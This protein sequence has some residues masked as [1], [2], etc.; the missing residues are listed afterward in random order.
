MMRTDY[1]PETIRNNRK[2]NRPGLAG[3]KAS[4]RTETSCPLTTSHNNC[5]FKFSVYCNSHGYYIKGGNPFHEFHAK[6]D[7]IRFPVNL[8]LRNRRLSYVTSTMEPTP[9]LQLLSKQTHY[10]CSKRANTPTLFSKA[11]IKYLCFKKVGRNIDLPNLQE[12]STWDNIFKHIMN[13]K[14]EHIALMQRVVSIPDTVT[15]SDIPIRMGVLF[16]KKTFQESGISKQDQPI[17][18]DK[19]DAMMAEIDISLHR[20][21]RNI[22]HNQEMVV[23]LAF[24]TP[25]EIRQFQ[26]F[27]TVLHINATADTNNKTALPKLNV[28]AALGISLTVVGSLCISCEVP[29]WRF[30]S[31]E[32]SKAS[33]G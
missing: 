31:Q 17:L 3:R 4:H 1:R 8:D 15:G 33:I 30:W 16:N 26:L 6:R 24:T 20:T 9:L 27:H 7:E 5:P 23:G 28:L 21:K 19:E 25:A 22:A 10:I 18:E 14:G 32:A 2:N 12:N 13:I 29:P 11:Q